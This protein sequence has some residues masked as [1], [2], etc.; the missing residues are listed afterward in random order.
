MSPAA[1]PSE[2]S[3]LA[4][5]DEGRGATTSDGTSTNVGNRD[6]RAT[7]V[8]SQAEGSKDEGATSPAARP[9][10]SSLRRKNKKEF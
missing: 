3:L 6:A 9:D 8:G 5:A 2:N 1:C 10:E 7:N 4:A